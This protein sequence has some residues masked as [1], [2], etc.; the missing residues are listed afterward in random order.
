MLKHITLKEVHGIW[1]FRCT[2]NQINGKKPYDVANFMAVKRKP[3]SLLSNG[4]N[5]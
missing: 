4:L 3:A 1:L 2:D 5:H